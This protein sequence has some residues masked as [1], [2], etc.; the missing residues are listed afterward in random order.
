MSGSRQPATCLHGPAD[1]RISK[2][3]CQQKRGNKSRAW[4]GLAT[5]G[6]SMAILTG[7]SIPMYF[8]QSWDHTYALSDDGFLWSCFGR[9]TG[10]GKICTDVGD[11]SMADCLAQPNSHAGII[12]L[13]TGVCHQAAS[14]ILWPAKLLVDQ[15]GGYG[16]SYALFGPYGT[17]PCPWPLLEQC[18]NFTVS[19]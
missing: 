5:G 1:L 7:F 2:L 6:M 14:R 9:T 3:K 4:R 8:R 12:Y 18:V 13:V 17:D 16:W 10:G 15:A 19:G 11:S